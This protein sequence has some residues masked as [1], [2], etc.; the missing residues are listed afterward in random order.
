MNK[1]LKISAITLVIL[2]LVLFLHLYGMAENLY[3][4]IWYYDIILHILGGMG[5][6]LSV[7]SVIN[8]FNIDFLKKRIWSIVALSFVGG[9]A[10][11]LFEV[12]YSLTGSELWSKPYYID[13]IKDLFDDTLGALIIWGIVKNK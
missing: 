3:I 13:T 1:N 8:I 11:E 10:W 5:I 2:L 7:Y 4:K 12:L 6:A 9:L